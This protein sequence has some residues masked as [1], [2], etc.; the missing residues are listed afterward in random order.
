M[1]IARFKGLENLLNS[2]C[3]SY[4][5]SKKTARF[6]KIKNILN[7]LCNDNEGEINKNINFNYFYNRDNNT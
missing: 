4:R 3:Y 6:S 5:V 2:E 1:Y 7:L